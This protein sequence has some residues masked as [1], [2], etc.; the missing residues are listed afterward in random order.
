M[1]KSFQLRGRLCPWPPD[2]VLCPCTP[3][4]HNPR[5]SLYAELIQPKFYF[6]CQN[7]IGLLICLYI[8]SKKNVVRCCIFCSQ[9]T[10]HSYPQCWPLIALLFCGLAPPLLTLQKCTRTSNTVVVSFQ[11]SAMLIGL[12]ST[13]KSL[14]MTE[15]VRG[16]DC[17]NHH[18]CNHG[19]KVGGD[20]VS[21]G[22]YRFPSLSIFLLPSLLVLLS[23]LPHQCCTHCLSASIPLFLNPLKSWG[24]L[25]SP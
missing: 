16:L 17:P 10:C 19:W 24:S 1:L 15:L 2:Q 18:R 4:E 20:H 13:V 11:S 21:G 9:I 8:T 5:P 7:W 12:T 3:L 25:P 14:D 22:G 23:L 6:L